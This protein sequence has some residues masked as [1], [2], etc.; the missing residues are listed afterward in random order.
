MSDATAPKQQLPTEGGSYERTEGGELQRSEGTE[1]APERAQPEPDG[2]GT[3]R[4]AEEEPAHQPRRSRRQDT[5][6]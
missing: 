6:E 1:A 3:A 5:Q 4:P 2:Q